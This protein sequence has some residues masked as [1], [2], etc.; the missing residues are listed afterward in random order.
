[1][2][3]PCATALN[4]RVGAETL[5]A[6]SHQALGDVSLKERTHYVSA[7]QSAS[8]R[9]V[10]YVG[11]DLSGGNA[12]VAQQTLHEAYIDP[13][14]KKQCRGRVSEHMGCNSLTDS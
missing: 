9:N 10:R 13:A 12:R 11:I 4:A 1:M 7:R 8:E 3:V 14:F 5:P 2:V 6:G